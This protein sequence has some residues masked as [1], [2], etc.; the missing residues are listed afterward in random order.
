MSEYNKCLRVGCQKCCNIVGAIRWDAWV[1]ER[2][3]AGL[4]IERILSL[5]LP[6]KR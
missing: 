6:F 4:E 1:G 2:W 5:E 3:S